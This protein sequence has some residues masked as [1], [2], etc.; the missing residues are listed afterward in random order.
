MLHEGL[1]EG[2]QE[3]LDALFKYG[4]WNEKQD[5]REL[6]KFLNIIFNF[7]IMI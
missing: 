2:S 3:Y 7:K 5:F 4:L 1:E 6:S